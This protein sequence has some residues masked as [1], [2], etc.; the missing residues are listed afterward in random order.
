MY[1]QF[2]GLEKP[3]FSLTPDPRFLYMTEAHQNAR[4][5][6]MYSILSRKGF[7][8]LTGDAGTGKTTL[9]RAVINSIPQDRICF[10]FLLNPALSPDDFYE[11]TVRD[12]GLPKGQGKADRL[13]NLESFLLHAHAEGKISVLFVDEAHRLSVE[14]LEEIRLLTNFE[15]ECEKLLQIVLVGQDELDEMLDRR[16]L[17]QLKQRVGV[18]LHI[19][20]LSMNAVGGYIAHRWKCVSPAAPPFSE[21]AIRS[22]CQFSSGIPRVINSICDNALLIAYAGGSKVVT[23]EHINEAS[24]DLRLGRAEVK[25]QAEK[26]EVRR[27]ASDDLQVPRPVSRQLDEHP[28]PG[29]GKY[30]PRNAWWPRFLKAAKV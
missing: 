26:S 8:V 29:L 19:G 23:Q 9:L 24:R 14:T 6:L 30:K 20:P 3:P 5:G 15:T 13:W 25:H 7:T 18:R 12:F 11:A 21:E 28:L 1:E 4:A 2:Y 27:V 22:V 17:R 16:E 10:S